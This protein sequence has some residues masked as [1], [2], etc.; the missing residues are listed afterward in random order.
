MKPCTHYH[1]AGSEEDQREGKKLLEEGALACLILAGGQATR[2]GF[3][4]PKGCYPLG[5]TTL[6]E[7]F[8]KQLAHYPV[9]TA[10]MASPKNFAT[11]AA[12]LAKSN[13]EVFE[14]KMLPFLDEAG[15]PLDVFGPDGNGGALQCLAAAGIL[16]KWK[17]KRVRFINIILV[18]N[19]LADPCD[20]ELLGFGA[21]TKAD[22]VLKCTRRE[23]LNE[24]AGVVIEGPCVV[25][26]SEACCGPEFNIINLSLFLLTLEFAEEI[27]QL[28]LPIHLVKKKIPEHGVMGIKQER[29]LFDLLPCAKRPEVLV[30]P[31]EKCFAPLKEVSDVEKILKS[32]ILSKN[33]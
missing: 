10:V 24:K 31:R 2:L 17:H 18:D 9:P 1:L 5:N 26:Y 33:S 11:T 7:I 21:R 23:D 28:E 27:S 4:G 13:V 30:Y 29:F 6:F 32:G 20:V 12:Y 14:Q 8:L 19:A 25:E 15:N 16:A 3:E 22:V